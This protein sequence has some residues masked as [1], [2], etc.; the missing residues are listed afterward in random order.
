MLVPMQT[1]SLVRSLALG[2]ALLILLA[3]SGNMT[4]QG[5]YFYQ[6]RCRVDVGDDLLLWTQSDYPDGANVTIDGKSATITD[7]DRGK[8]RVTVPAGVSAGAGKRVQVRNGVVLVS[9]GTVTIGVTTPT[10]ETEPN[11]DVDGLD[12]TFVRD[13]N[14]EATGN[15]S[16]FADKDHFEFDCITRGLQYEISVQ[17]PGAGQ[18][19]VNGQ[20]V[21]LDGT[22]KG[23]F[24]NAS[25]NNKCLVGITGGT[26]NYKITLGGKL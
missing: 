8:L 22:G 4:S 18:V 10:S 23:V 9:E 25:A 19:F 2:L 20:A 24:N 17:P 11:D 7:Q 1:S 13:M 6:D 5:S 15:L 3:C 16:S 12:A 26:G 14:W 21:A